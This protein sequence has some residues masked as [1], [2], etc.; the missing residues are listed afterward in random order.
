TKLGFREVRR[1]PHYSVAH[2]GNVDCAVLALDLDD[3]GADM[4]SLPIAA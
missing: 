1:E 2:R 3:N 4:R